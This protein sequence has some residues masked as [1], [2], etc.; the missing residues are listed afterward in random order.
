MKKV[1]SIKAITALFLAVFIA[2]ASAISFTTAT[3]QAATTG[4]GLGCILPT[5][6]QVTAMPKAVAPTLSGPLPTSVDLTSQF[7]PPGNQGGQGSCTAW[8]VAYALKSMHEGQTRGWS[9]S[10][11]DHQ[12]SPAYVY[13]QINGGSDNGSYIGDAMNL[14]VNQGCCT[15]QTMPY[16][17]NDYTT[18]PNATQKAEAQ[19]YKEANWAQLTYSYGSGSTATVNT[20]KEYL[21]GNDGVVLSIPIYYNYWTSGSP[22]FNE[23]GSY[24]GGHA[25]CLVGYNDNLSMPDGSTGAFK[26]INSWGSGWGSSG[27]G[28]VP[29]SYIIKDVGPYSYA[30]FVAYVMTKNTTP[31][32]SITLNKT[33]DSIAAGGTDTLVATISPSNAN[34]A[35]IWSSSNTNVATVANNG[36]VTAK[37]AGTATIT[38]ST[39]YGGKSA[40]CAVTVTAAPTSPTVTFNANGG[41]GTMANQ[42][43]TSGVAQALTANAFTRTGYTF[44]GWATSATGAVVYT[45]GQSISITSSITLYAVWKANTYTVVFNAN[46]GTGTMANQTFTY[47]VA[48]ALTANAF[49]RAS[50][51]FLGWSTSSTATTATYTN[52]QS[53]SNLTATNGGTVTLYAVWQAAAVTTYTVTFNAN[54]G[55]GTMAAQTFTSGVAQALTANAFT[56]T[57]YT[58]LGWSTS[59]TATTATYTDKQS[60]TITANTTLYAVWKAN[61]YTVTF[62]AN[63]GTGTMANQSFT[64]DIAQALTAN[65]FTRASY[66]FLGWSTSSTATTAT[67]TNSQSVSNLTATNGATVTLY[68][69]WQ[70][71]PPTVTFNANGGTGTMANQIFT[72]GVAQALAAN[73]FTR[74]GY[75]F[76]GWATT[77]TGAVAYTN[78]QSISITSSITLYAV[79]KA[80]TYTVAFNANGGSGTMANQA[81]T[82]DIAQALTANA[83]TRAGYMFLGWSTTSTA[84]TAT[85]TNSQSVSNLTA[86]NAATV[87]LYA[88][89]QTAAK[90]TNNRLSDGWTHVI[91][92]KPDGTVWAWGS[93]SYGQLGDG[94]T[95]NRTTPVQVKGLTGVV[96]VSACNAASIALKSDGTVWAWGD[97]A[98]NELGD[99]TTTNRTTPV[100]VSGLTG[101]IAVAEGYLSGIALKSDGT[102]WTWG[103]QFSNGTT[104]YNAIPVQIAGLTGVTSVAASYLCFIVSKSDG[105]V[106]TWGSNGFGQLGN[107]TAASNTAGSAVPVQVSGLTGVVS[108]AAGKNFSVALKSDGT[109][110]TWGDNTYG[111]LGDGTNTART[112]PVQASGLSGVISVNPGCYHVAAIKSDG[113]VWGWGTNNYGQLGNGT[114]TDRAIPMQINGL[115]GAVSAAGGYLFTAVLKSDGTLWTFGA[116][117]CGQLGNGT[118]TDSLVPVQVK[119]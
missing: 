1:I 106:W 50:Y 59:S 25:I 117:D 83:F 8:A 45:N 32:T 115:S 73:A 69:V 90:L 23:D 78:G 62:N 71:I 97:N 82:Y 13:N 91:Y 76:Q 75:T 86:T 107:G 119:L 10:T 47:D 79:W 55:T 74:T 40:S 77:A 85:Y 16:N 31:A 17:Q 49:T 24:V 109:V 44:Q 39:V 98:Y 46:G 18:Q 15:L 3:V 7:P 60:I 21:A 52:S 4:Y 26:F 94:T 63:G 35:T 95:T 27:F 61:T 84:T 114:K 34:Q 37:S 54:G 110:W 72:S 43:F 66:T 56:K 67:Y 92:L 42:T 58:F 118:T 22:Y 105:T 99:G 41:S 89:W 68:A 2:S 80:N 101:V 103:C 36:V 88:V 53:V 48:Q 19:N 102:V 33:T 6:S 9:L 104:K 65:A 93:N 113:T 108:V 20:I 5:L 57:G 28:Y 14:M 111:Q 96:S 64:Y 11:S 38:V 100:Q 81:F 112:V 29:Y 12:F 70:L 87:T 51:T 116:N 30:N